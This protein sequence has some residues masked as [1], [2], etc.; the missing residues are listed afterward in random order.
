MKGIGQAEYGSG[1]ART[2][3]T[4]VQ[5]R[6]SALDHELLEH[7]EYCGAADAYFAC[8]ISDEAS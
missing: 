2:H 8:D 5:P 4:S 3:D 7:V 6:R 1:E